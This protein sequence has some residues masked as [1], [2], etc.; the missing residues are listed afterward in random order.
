MGQSQKGQDSFIEKILESI[1]VEKGYFVE[2]GAVDGIQSSNSWHLR[3][4]K[5]WTGLLLEGGQSNPAINLHDEFITAEN[6]CSIFKKYN[7]PEEIDFLSV[8]IDGQDGVVLESILKEY[9]IKLVM[10]EV[11]ARCSPYQNLW[12]KFNS[13]WR[14]NGRTWY[15]SS[16]LA[17][18]KMAGKYGMTPVG[19]YL[20]DM[21]LVNNKFLTS[22][23]IDVNLEDIYEQNVEIYESH[24]NCTFNQN[25]FE[26]YE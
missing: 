21:F 5:G 7:V 16:P 26:E 11:N 13:N 20:D 8:D 19:V 10:I 1:G 24:G 2:F 4:N 17:L 12:Q 3:I 15:G 14:W 22:V 6:I 9:N 25:D 23:E 18:K